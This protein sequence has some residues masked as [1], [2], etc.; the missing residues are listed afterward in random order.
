MRKPLQ[1]AK[2]LL[3]GPM[4]YEPPK[5]PLL[6]VGLLACLYVSPFALRQ[7]PSVLSIT[8]A[9]GP[10]AGQ[11]ELLDIEVIRPILS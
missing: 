6:S 2:R 1:R 8:P 4:S 10:A 5:A 3:K 11:P 7:R 9:F